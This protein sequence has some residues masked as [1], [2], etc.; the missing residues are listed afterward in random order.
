MK[1]QS[2]HNTVHSVSRQIKIEDCLLENLLS[3]P[4]D[5]ISVADMCRQ[6]GISRRL[7]YTYFPDKDACL[8]SL[9]DRYIY[10][11]VANHMNDN[12][13]ERDYDL[14]A[15]TVAYLR[16]WQNHMDF[17]SMITRQNLKSL[18]VDRTHIC[19]RE[20]FDQL[21]DQLSTPDFPADDSTIW[22]YAAFCFTIL[23]QWYEQGCQIPVEE[24]ARRYLRM[25]RSPLLHDL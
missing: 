18:M 11:S 24:M 10:G 23:M 1:Q 2:P 14:T 6:M 7:Y 4:F 13:T 20:N 22:L 25:L 15:S 12:Y 17:L 16:Y 8:V 19:F 21:L 3:V 5:R 9:I